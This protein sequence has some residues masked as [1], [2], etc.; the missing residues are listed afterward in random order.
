MSYKF[1]TGIVEKFDGSN[2]LS[3]GT[4]CQFAIEFRADLL[5]DD[6]HELLHLLS[7]AFKVGAVAITDAI[8]RHQKNKSG[9]HQEASCDHGKINEQGTSKAQP[10]RRNGNDSAKTSGA[11]GGS[12]GQKSAS[13]SPSV[14]SSNQPASRGQRRVIK[15]ICKRLN[16]MPEVAA[17]NHHFILATITRQ[18]ASLLLDQLRR[19]ET[20]PTAARQYL[21]QCSN[22]S[23][24]G[25][26]HLWPAD[27]SVRSRQA[28][29]A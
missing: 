11:S 14:S 20:N 1:T 28:C 9:T 23:D 16:I 5:N 27:R 6:S 22:R 15:S 10:F 13:G 26:V 4:S 12:E 3:N 25:Q 2:D 8:H 21:C 7:A 29:C 18:Q 17:D 19:L 24:G